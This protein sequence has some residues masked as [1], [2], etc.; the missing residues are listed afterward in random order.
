MWWPCNM[1]GATT[2]SAA[3]RAR[4][5]SARAA[6]PPHR[7]RAQWRARVS[8]TR[9]TAVPWRPQ[10]ARRT[11]ALHRWRVELVGAVAC[12][13]A[14]SDHNQCGMARSDHHQ[15]GM[16]RARRKQACCA[17]FR[18][19]AS[20]VA[21]SRARHATAGCASEAAAGTSQHGL[22]PMNSGLSPVHWPFIVHEATTTSA[23]R[24]TRFASARAVP[25]PYRQQAQWRARMRATRK[26]AVPR[27]PQLVRRTTVLREWRETSR[28]CSAPV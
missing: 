15:C 21:R 13:I 2:T 27:R 24:L 8:A 23:A 19:T 5:A 20:A 9:K 18:K 28:R 25:P 4:V 22:A 26:P 12:Y 6:P 10:L 1:H 7:Q 11:T 17:S 16:A 3:W 14:R